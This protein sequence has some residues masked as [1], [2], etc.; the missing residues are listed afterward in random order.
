VVNAD[1]AKALTTL[2]ALTPS[3][4]RPAL[5]VGKAEV[6][7]P[8]PKVPRPLKAVTLLNALDALVEKRAD[9]L[10]RLDASSVISV[11][12]RRRGSR[13]VSDF[14]DPSE[15]Q[16]LRVRRRTDGGI[17]IVDKNP[18]FRDFVAELLKRHHLSIAWVNDENKAAE[19]CHSQN[20]AVVLINTSMTTVEPYGL[21]EEIKSVGSGES[22]TVIFLVSKAFTYDVQRAHGAGV[23][24]FLNKPV[25]AHHLQ[26][27]L[28]KFMPL[29]SK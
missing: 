19:Q 15:Y 9:T 26:S 1:E 28:K 14:A 3:D 5:L 17:L 2:S 29:L 8:F 13:V 11:P 7:L 21:C 16:R 25:A 23:D 27:V 12:E 22:A 18:A 20:F 6:K 24:G 10:S 4:V